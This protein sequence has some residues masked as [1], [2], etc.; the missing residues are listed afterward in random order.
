MDPGWAAE[1]PIVVS[2]KV[3]QG[4]PTAAVSKRVLRARGRIDHNRRV[5]EWLDTTY[6]GSENEVDEGYHGA[7]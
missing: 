4:E 1:T 7:K 6:P 2:S 3:W 5:L